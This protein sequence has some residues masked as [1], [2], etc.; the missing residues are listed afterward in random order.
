MSDAHAHRHPHAA[1]D[2]SSDYEPLERAL[3]E[4]LVEKGVFTRRSHPAPDRGHG[5]PDAGERRAA[6]RPRLGGP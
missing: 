1:D 3:R 4:L 5:Q 2:P 6:R